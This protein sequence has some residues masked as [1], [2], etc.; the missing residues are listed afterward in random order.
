M[1]NSSLQINAYQVTGS[2]TE[3][4]IIASRSF[5]ALPSRNMTVVDFQT[6]SGSTREKWTAYDITALAKK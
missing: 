3:S 1:E 2:W 4:D 5:S 6:V